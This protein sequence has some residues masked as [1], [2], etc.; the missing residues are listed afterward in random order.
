MTVSE[1]GEVDYVRTVS[2]LPSLPFVCLSLC[3][4]KYEGDTSPEIRCTTNQ[5][6][7]HVG[8]F[9]YNL[10]GTTLSK[11]SVT[12]ERTPFKGFGLCRRFR[13]LSQHDRYLGEYPLTCVFTTNKNDS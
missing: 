6:H 7:E 9:I 11:V 13:S 5:L 4:P 8:S 2:F 1:S 10:M 3:V 12:V